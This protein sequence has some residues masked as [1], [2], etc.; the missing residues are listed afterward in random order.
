MSNVCPKN[1]EI[2]K[3]IQ[4][5]LNNGQQLLTKELKLAVISLMNLKEGQLAEK[6][7]SGNGIRFNIRFSTQLSEL[8]KSGEFVKEI[9]GT[10]YKPETK[11][12]LV[13]DNNTLSELEMLNQLLDQEEAAA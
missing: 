10:I 2:K 9:D 11:L 7:E 6:T 3:A 1:S 4:S 8:I 12:T 13:I 5:I